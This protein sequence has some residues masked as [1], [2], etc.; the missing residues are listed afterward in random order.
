VFAWLR[1]YLTAISP[2][3]CKNYLLVVVQSD[4]VMSLHI[5]LNNLWLC[6]RSLCMLTWALVIGKMMCVLME[7]KCHQNTFSFYFASA[8]FS[9]LSRTLHIFCGPPPNILSLFS[10]KS[11][12]F[13]PF[14]KFLFPGSEI[15]V[16]P[17]SRN[18]IPRAGARTRGGLRAG[19]TP[20]GI[21]TPGYCGP[22]SSL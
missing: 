17:N 14:L 11:V 2:L 18:C 21:G 15:P 3:Q 1:R 7:F 6:C 8:L 5:S 19:M 13:P 20:P 16:F 4:Y 10:P 22:S 9:I 12:C